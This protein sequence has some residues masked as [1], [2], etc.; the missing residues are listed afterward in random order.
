MF[1]QKSCRFVV[2]IRQ[3]TNAFIRGGSALKPKRPIKKFL[4]K[5]QSAFCVTEQRDS[6]PSLRILRALCLHCQDCKCVFYL[7]VDSAAEPP[8]RPASCC[9]DCGSANLTA[10]ELV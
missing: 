3:L 2:Y 6:D 1:F 5:G 4:L 7:L 9:P 8:E 10:F